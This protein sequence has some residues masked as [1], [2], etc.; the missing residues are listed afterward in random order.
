MKFCTCLANDS[1]RGNPFLALEI[2]LGGIRCLLG[3]LSPWFILAGLMPLE[4]HPFIFLLDF[5]AWW[6]VCINIYPNGVLNFIHG[7]HND[8][9]FISHLI[10]LDCGSQRLLILFIFQKM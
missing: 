7:C 8:S 1:T 10:N 9:P 2:L 3:A 6:K 5:P 4:S